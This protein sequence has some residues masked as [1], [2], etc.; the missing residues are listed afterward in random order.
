MKIKVLKATVFFLLITGFLIGQ[1]TITQVS[2]F[3]TNP[4]NLNMYTYLAN[5]IN[6]SAPLVIALHG[7]TQS[8]NEY[9]TQSGWN[10]LA[11]LHRFYVV[12]PEQIIANNSSKCFTWFDT[13]DVNKNQ[14][15]SLSI[16][17]M[18]DYM[19]SHYNI[20]S[21]EIYVTG[22]SAGAAM[23]V[24][25]LADYPD[26]F[27]KGAVMAGVPYK[28]A[29]S[30]LYAY[31]AMNGGIIKTPAQWGALVRN[32]NPNY[33]GTFPHVAIF[34]GT[35]DFTVN[36]ANATEII[37]QWT[38]VNNADQTADN[39]FSSFDG[40]TSIEKIVYNDNLNNSVVEYYKIAGMGHAISLD[41]GACPRQGG[42]VGTYATEKGFHSTYWAADF[43]NIL[44]SPYNITGAISTI[45]NATNV[46]YS[47]PFYS[48]STYS[49][50]VPMGATI[51]NGQGTNTI[52]VDF[53]N[54]SG[55]VQVIETTSGSCKNDAAKLYVETNASAVEDLS[56]NEP[57]LFYCKE[58]NSITAI[59]INLNDLKSLIIY[60]SIGQKI[61]QPFSIR[62]NKIIFYTDFKTG[63][64]F[65]NMNLGQTQHTFKIIVF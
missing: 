62:G 4:G 14:G 21:S 17:Q 43:F 29:T 38:N 33:S 52:V 40:N 26:I 60:N 1:T 42:A 58:E 24:A 15:E 63:I 47:V 34:H 9:A 36:T 56:S 25:L 37:K 45:P 48:G 11:Q 6:G 39:T 20:N 16:K 22:I 51:S 59:N 8:A 61:N 55:Y 44:S 18:V 7:C 53:G 5:G 49:W 50:I 3:G 12:Y 19:I 28:A 23:T 32:Q 64:Y 27:S 41:T 30:S 35:Q 2:N 46:I 31:T 54:N 13:T 65:V 57:K 10:K